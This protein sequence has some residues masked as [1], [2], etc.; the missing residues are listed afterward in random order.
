MKKLGV[1]LVAVAVLLS[2]GFGLSGCGEQKPPEVKKD[3]TKK[4]PE[5]TPEEIAAKIRQEILAPIAAEAAK[6]DISPD[7][8]QRLVG[9]VGQARTANQNT[10]NGKKAL[11]M[12]ANEL[13][14]QAQQA[15]AVKQWTV[16]LAAVEAYGALQP[17]SSKMERLKEQATRRGEQAQGA[18]AHVHDG[19]REQAHDGHADADDPR[20]RSDQGCGRSRRATSSRAFGSTRLS[21]T[22][23]A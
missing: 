11:D 7:A 3:D 17:G 20:Y 5:P 15:K 4:P 21:A 18:P 1:L 23:A 8:R 19:S 22:S 10:E 14:L 13:D 2:V 9:A 16:V 6:G 12:I